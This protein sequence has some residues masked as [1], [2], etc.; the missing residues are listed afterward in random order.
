MSNVPAFIARL[1]V[2]AAALE[3]NSP[4]AKQ[5]AIFALR[6]AAARIEVDNR[7]TQDKDNAS[8]PESFGGVESGV[9]FAGKPQGGETRERPN[10][11]ALGE[12][13]GPSLQ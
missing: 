3:E 7:S 8:E 6:A 13:V 9:Y 5:R 1:R 2:I 11:E 4:H 10:G 12:E